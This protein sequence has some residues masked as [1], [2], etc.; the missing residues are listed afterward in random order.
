MARTVTKFGI[1]PVDK[2]IGQRVKARRIE[3]RMSQTTLAEALQ[4]TFQQIQKYENG[5][6]RLSG[7]T[8]YLTAKAL[9]VP[10]GY[11][12]EGY[13]EGVPLVAVAPR[14][15]QCA[16]LVE[17]F[18]QMPGNVQVKFQQLARAVVSPAAQR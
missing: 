15:R 6:N 9:D 1:H 17:A 16:D 7:S 4:L 18:E 8:M 3:L 12:F 13:E 11:F 5:S 10:P 2:Y 14:S